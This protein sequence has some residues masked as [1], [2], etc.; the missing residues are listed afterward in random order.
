HPAPTTGDHQA[1][2]LAQS[3]AP[4]GP[5]RHPRAD[6]ALPAR[7]PPRRLSGHPPQ[8]WTAGGNT[9]THCKV[10]DISTTYRDRST[11][12]CIQEQEHNRERG[13]QQNRRGGTPTGHPPST[14]TT[15]PVPPAP[16]PP[17]PPPPP[18]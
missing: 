17:P 3:L 18:P 10:T 6:P 2:H 9:A 14:A 13:S 11:S 12:R 4:G 7:P 16:A 15:P 1:R 8:A 5:G